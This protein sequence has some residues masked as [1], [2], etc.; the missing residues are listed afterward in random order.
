MSFTKHGVRH[1]EKGMEKK[2]QRLEKTPQM[3]SSTS[4]LGKV[5]GVDTQE[6]K[7]TLMTQDSSQ[8]AAIC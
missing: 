3:S 2:Q 5:Q 7:I 4:I 6:E 8:Q 1:A